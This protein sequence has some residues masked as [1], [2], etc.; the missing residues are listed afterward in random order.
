[1]AIKAISL[2]W[3]VQSF[4]MA[5]MV[6]LGELEPIDFAIHADTT[7]ERI[8]TYQFAERWEPWLGDHG[9]EVVTVSNPQDAA[10]LHGF[11]TDIPAF[12]WNGKSRGQLRRQ[13][14]GS[15]KIQPMRKYFTQ[16]IRSRGLK[17]TSGVVESWLGITL[18]EFQRMKESDVKYIT[19]RWPLIELKMTRW[20]CIRWLEGHGLEVPPRSSCVFCPYHDKATWAAM[21]ANATDWVRATI[22]DEKIR[23]KRP[24]YDLFVHQERVP[25]DK[26][27]L[28]TPEERGQ[29]SLWN[30]E[31]SGVCGV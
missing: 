26:I 15:W 3:G 14:T 22:M 1:M 11:Q 23:D 17:K 9:V 6:A 31:C 16:E 28:R 5:A 2:G 18:D 8:G 30:D 10:E 19:N 13:C 12:T 25:L 21:K 4:T 27:D 7:H 24:P 20:D 29:L